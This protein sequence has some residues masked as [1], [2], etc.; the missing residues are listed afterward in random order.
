LKRGFINF[1]NNLSS[2]IAIAVAPLLL[3]P[4]SVALQLRRL[5]LQVCDLRA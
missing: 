5:S 3:N 1:G 4:G 2:V